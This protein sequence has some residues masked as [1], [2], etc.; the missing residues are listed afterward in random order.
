[1]WN[2]SVAL[3][4][5][6]SHRPTSSCLRARSSFPSSLSTDHDTHYLFCYHSQLIPLLSRHT[7]SVNHH[8]ECTSLPLLLRTNL[9]GSCPASA[10]FK[11]RRPSHHWRPRLQGST[12]RSG[13]I[14][15]LRHKGTF[16]AVLSTSGLHHIPACRHICHILRT[17]PDVVFDRPL[18]VSSTKS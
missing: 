6:P 3:L 10:S 2:A 15:A 16:W 13:V 8:T 5:S 12:S 18:E 4:V 7:P 1:M 9:A 11:C 17:E 14:H